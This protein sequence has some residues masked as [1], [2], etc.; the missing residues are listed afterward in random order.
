MRESCPTG[1]ICQDPRTGLGCGVW[2][3]R[4]PA[5][6]DAW[7]FRCRCGEIAGPA[8]RVEYETARR[9]VLP[10]IEEVSAEAI[11]P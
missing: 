2:Y 11:S 7:W 1:Y 5:G 4:D 8:T 9:P 3:D 10:G 6:T